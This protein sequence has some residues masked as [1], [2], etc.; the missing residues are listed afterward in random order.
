[1]KK[2]YPSWY[3]RYPKT[4]MKYNNFYLKECGRFRFNSK[5]VSDP[6]GYRKMS[7]ERVLADLFGER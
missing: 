1:M 7:A 4:T 2:Y 3:R 6:D 5:K